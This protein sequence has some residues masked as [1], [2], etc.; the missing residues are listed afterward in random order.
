M[1]DRG[2]KGLFWEFWKKN[3]FEIKEPPVY[4]FIKEDNHYLLFEV[5]CD[6]KAIL[7]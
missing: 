3:D 1:W 6:A 5:V 4:V 7:A 2:A